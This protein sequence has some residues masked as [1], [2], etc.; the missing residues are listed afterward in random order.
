MQL[1]EWGCICLHKVWK[2]GK[3]VGFMC[4]FGLEFGVWVGR[5]GMYKGVNM[6]VYWGESG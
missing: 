3:N 4:C 5:V 6:G 1:D 2:V